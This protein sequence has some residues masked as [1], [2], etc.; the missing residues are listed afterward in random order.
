MS[1]GCN[2]CATLFPINCVAICSVPTAWLSSRT[3]PRTAFVHWRPLTRESPKPLPTECSARAC[4]ARRPPFVSRRR[5]DDPSRLQAFSPTAGCCLEMYSSRV[6]TGP[7]QSSKQALNAATI[8]ARSAH[9]ASRQS[10]TLPTAGSS[11]ECSCPSR[12]PPI[13]RCPPGSSSQGEPSD[14]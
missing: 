1:A 8:R 13:L 10:P 6:E 4:V 9:R 14:R 11:A 12:C 7:S 5:S 2:G 3:W